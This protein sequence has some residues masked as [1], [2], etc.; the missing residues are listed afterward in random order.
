MRIELQK[1]ESERKFDELKSNNLSDCKLLGL[2]ARGTVRETS[3]KKGL[4]L[5]RDQ[6]QG[7]VLRGSPNADKQADDG[8]VRDSKPLS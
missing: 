4:R 6:L 1:S 2:V 3:A 7:V 5:Q 8:A